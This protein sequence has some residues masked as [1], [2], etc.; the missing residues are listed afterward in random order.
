ML[1]LTTRP[2]DQSD[3]EDWVRLWTDYLSFY[4]T[5]LPQEIYESTWRRL[6]TRGEFEPRGILAIAE[7]SIIGLVHYLYH[8]SCW[9]VANNCYL[10]D[11]YTDPSMRGKGVGEALIKVVRR[12][13]AKNGIT[14]VN[15]MTHETNV[16]AR[17]LYD[18]VARK[19]GFM[20]Y[21]LS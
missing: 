12:E 6:F 8:R 3:H 13:A 2:L 21:D 15:W 11:L 16:T 14:N 17:K 10:Q 5:T 1:A 4:K 9:S 18:R 20:E 7:G 19:T